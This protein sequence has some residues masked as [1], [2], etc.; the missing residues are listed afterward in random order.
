MV[1]LGE[2]PPNNL[3]RPEVAKMIVSF[4]EPFV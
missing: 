4:T 3:M 2:M 1:G